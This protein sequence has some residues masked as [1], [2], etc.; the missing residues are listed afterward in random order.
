MLPAPRAQPRAPPGV[1][2][3]LRAARRPVRRRSSTTTSR[4]MKTA[5]VE[6]IF[7]RLKAALVPMVARLGPSRS[8]TRACAAEFPRERSA[9]S[10]SRCSSAGGWTARRGGSTARCIRSRLALADRHPPDDELP[11]GQPHGILSCL[12][13]FGHGIYE[14]QVD[15]R[16]PHAARSKACR[17]RSTSRRAACG[18]TSSAAA[19]RRGGSSIRGCRRVPRAVRRRPARGRSIA[20]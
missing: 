14:R 1:R 12:H 13:E 18:R 2:R 7:A 4:G 17:R 10:R 16:T 20:R 19:S 8:T 15:P 6:A 3:V 5:E 9:R 11:R